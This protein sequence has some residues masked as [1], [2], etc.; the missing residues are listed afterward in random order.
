MTRTRL[1]LML[2]VVVCQ[3]LT[4]WCTWPVW[5]TRVDPPNLPLLFRIEVSVGWLM[6]GSLALTLLRP[7]LGTAVHAVVLAMAILLDQF[8]LQPQ[9]FGLAIL[10]AAIVFEPGARLVRWYFASVWLWAGIH[11]L[12]SSD[13][14]G[15]TSWAL[16]A[17]LEADPDALHLPFAV[18]VGMAE[19]TLGLLAIFQPSK[20]AIPCVV[21]HLGISL[22]MSPLGV[23]MNGSI[24]P[25]NIAM[26]GVGYWVM[27]RSLRTESKRRYEAVLAAVSLIAPIGFYWGW[28]DRSLAS[29]LYSDSLPR[30]LI[31]SVEG[32]RLIEGSPSLGVPFPSQRRLLRQYFERVG[33]PGDKLHIADPRPWLPDEHYVL[34]RDRCAQAIDPDQFFETRTGE[35]AGVGI[36][37]S[38]AV[39]SL[40]RSGVR[41]LRETE[42]GMI[43]AVAFSPDGFKPS[44]LRHLSGLPNLREVQLSG[45]AVGDQDL[46]Q[47][48]SLRL[49]TGIGLNQT[50]VSDVGVTPLLALPYLRYIEC[51]QT[52]VSQQTLD[53]FGERVSR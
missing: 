3:A 15:P 16:L 29:V 38:S 35:V 37:L 17:R 8:R 23:D 41:L 42:G 12:V 18:A 30:G 33:R 10:L 44:L 20:A 48:T 7:R 51:E 26:A 28:V 1:R 32:W 11:K 52:A 25:W 9:F 43:Y 50:R 21:M 46:K 39:F 53:R 13:W 36:D 5:Q 22:F 40:A 4:L 27:S 34:G 47:L 31:T 2:L 24:I 6:L 45:T 14:L 49:L 19:L